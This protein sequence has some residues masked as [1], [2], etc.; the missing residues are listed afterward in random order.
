VAAEIE[1]RVEEYAR[2]RG[3]LAP[4]YELLVAPHHA[5]L[6]GDAHTPPLAEIRLAYQERLRF[7]HACRAIRDGA[8][9]SC[10]SLAP[11]GRNPEQW[12]DGHLLLYRSLLRPILLEGRCDLEA[13]RRA[14]RPAPAPPRGI[15]GFCA[16]VSQR[17]ADGCAPLPPTLRGLCLA[18]VHDDV[19]RCADSG[20]APARAGA[21]PDGDCRHF[22]QAA[23]ALAAGDPGLLAADA[24]ASA[25]VGAMLGRQGVCEQRFLQTMRPL[26][27]RFR[28]PAPRP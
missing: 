13:I 1:R 27:R 9:T 6:R 2:G 22:F 14:S 18:L 23:K 16:A 26:L 12:C 5:Q 4:L 20:P 10:R 25:Y 11:L 3:D 24:D 15:E 7:L 17:R 28:R 8:A 21:G 19:G